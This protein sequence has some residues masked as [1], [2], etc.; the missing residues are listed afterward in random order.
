MLEK[1]KRTMRTTRGQKGAARVGLILFTIVAIAMGGALGVGMA[2]LQDLPQT[3]A[4][5]DYRP[6]VVSRIH[7]A[8]G[9][10]LAELFREKRLLVP[11]SR[12]PKKLVQA[13][14]AT[15]DP[16]F[17]GH[18]GLDLKAIARAFLSNLRK[19]RIVEGG[20][21]ITQQLT[22]LL[23]LTP[24]R[25]LSRKVKEALLAFQLE[26][27]YTKDE[28]LELYFNQIYMGHGA[29][30]VEA[31]SRIYFGKGVEE[32]SLGEGALLAGIPRAP[33]LYDPLRNP[34]RALRRRNHVLRRM[35]EEGFLSAEEEK[36]AAAEPLSL[37]P[38]T[39]REN[40]APH[41]IEYVRRYL[42]DR[43]G[44]GAIYQRGLS[45]HTTLNSQLQVLARRALQGGLDA[46]NRRQGFRELSQGE[47]PHV[48][49]KLVGRVFSV[50]PERVMVQF[51]DLTATMKAREGTQGGSLR[52]GDK[53][54]AQVTR[55]DRAR[56]ELEVEEMEGVEGAVIAVDPQTGAIRAM[57][58][59]YDFARSQFNRAI[60]AR[61]QPGSAFKPFIY[62]TA[63]DNGFTPADLLIDSP[64]EYRNPATGDT[65]KPRNFSGKFHGPVTLR[66]ALE[67]SI[68]VATVKLL[69]RVGPKRVVEHAKAMGI[70][71]PIYPYLSMALGAF[72]VN[73]LEITGAYGVF[74]TGGLRAEPMAIVSVTDREGRLLEERSPRVYRVLKPETAYLLTYLLR[75]VIQR[76]T[77]SGARDLGGAVAGKTG[78]TDEFRDAWFVGFSPS[79]VVGVWVGLDSHNPIGKKETGARAALPIWKEIMAGWLKGR[80]AEEFNEPPGIVKLAVDA[81]TGRLAAKDC[82]PSLLEAFIEGTEPQESCKPQEPLIPLLRGG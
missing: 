45:I 64:V 20:S 46:L 67:E 42:E 60:Q 50:E 33:A 29:Y 82:G 69:E 23:F 55:V 37:A 7:D 59:G 48:G 58:G 68:N 27:R 5:E 11:L 49:Q 13:T 14:L 31:A 10:L 79:L 77:G 30:G 18:G 74:A 57:V 34:L 76:G 73:L 28:I 47:I 21:T 1:G 40:I 70:Q 36:G 51:G 56:G 61:R 24:E 52:P 26:R 39:G 75:G 53:V 35:R 6:D 81:R 16:R 43:Y 72:E 80:P 54:L 71:S 41:F 44:T 8:D 19:R 15:E 78:T 9:Q 62:A 4:L 65:W 17:Y 66:R 32:L 25:S 22:K 3:K 2:Y 12:I 38:S 63:I